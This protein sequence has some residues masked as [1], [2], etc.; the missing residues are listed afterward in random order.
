ME[1]IGIDI[2]YSV[3]RVNHWEPLSG[4][5]DCCPSLQCKAGTDFSGFLTWEVGIFE[6][7]RLP[8]RDRKKLSVHVFDFCL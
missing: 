8:G 1:N 7:I 4:E 5:I 2:H 3:S 6:D